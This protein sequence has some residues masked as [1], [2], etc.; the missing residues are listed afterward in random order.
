MLLSLVSSLSCPDSTCNPGVRVP[1]PSTSTP[2][3]AT[4]FSPSAS[5]AGACQW[6]GNVS[7]SA[8]HVDFGLA[9][10]QV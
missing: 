8:F 4:E 10:S 3:F 9:E 1:A 6:G 2:A 5:N 7:G